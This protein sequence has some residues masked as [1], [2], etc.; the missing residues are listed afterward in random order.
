M[1]AWRILLLGLLACLNTLVP[2]CSR[3]QS[4]NVRLQ[5]QC[6]AKTKEI[7]DLLAGVSDVP[8]ARAADPKIAAALGDLEKLEQQLERSY[9]PENVASSEQ[10]PM[11][12][13]IAEG[14]AEAQRMNAETLRIRQNPELVAAL[15]A[16]WK[17]LPSV[18]MMDAIQ[19]QQR[20]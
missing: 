19:G 16:T 11:T 3:R 17:K 7:A 14:I 1:R 8:S 6:N 18:I 12:E 4:Q 20:R 9:D 5:L 2:A 13:A 15:G 10:G